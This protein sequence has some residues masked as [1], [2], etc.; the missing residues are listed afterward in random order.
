MEG[1]KRE[2]DVGEKAG[3]D[4]RGRESSMSVG[5]CC[6]I[7][8]CRQAGRKDDGWKKW[9]GGKGGEARGERGE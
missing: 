1:G 7:S 5:G 9:S 3:K 2:E 8:G 6:K 4:E